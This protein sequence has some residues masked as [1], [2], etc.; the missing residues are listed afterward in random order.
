MYTILFKNEIFI[1]YLIFNINIPILQV[2]EDPE[3]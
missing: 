1:I 2:Y 3:G